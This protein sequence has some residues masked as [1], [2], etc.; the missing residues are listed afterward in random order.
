MDQPVDREANR[1][2]FADSVHRMI[3]DRPDNGIMVLV[4]SGVGVEIYQNFQN[5]SVMMG[6]L[7]VAKITVARTF[8]ASTATHTNAGE[9]RTMMSP[10]K[11][12]QN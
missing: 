10:G 2:A 9:I 12:Y 8:E 6:M 7:D 3:M 4:D 1:R 5:I 11:G